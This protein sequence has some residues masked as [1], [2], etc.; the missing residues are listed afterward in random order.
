MMEYHGIT[1]SKNEG[2]FAELHHVIRA[3]MQHFP[4]IILIKRKIKFFP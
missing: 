3:I 4:V 1:L 2:N